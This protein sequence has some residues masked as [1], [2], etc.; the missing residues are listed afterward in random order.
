MEDDL[1][2]GATYVTPGNHP[3]ARDAPDSVVMPQ[4]EHETQNADPD[5]D[6]DWAWRRRI[7]SRAKSY[8]IYR[9][10]VG[11][12]GA[13]VTIGGLVLIPAPGP[14][15]LIVFLGLAILASEFE[16]ANR[17]LA[18]ARHR[19][20]RWTDWVTRQPLPVRLL[21]G[22]ATLTLLAGI[23][24]VTLRLAGVPAF[25]PDSWVPSWSGLQH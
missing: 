6:G 18:Y 14:G 15:W 13:V 8:L 2:T 7:R 22:L 16:W 3:D 21:L 11:V 9:I 25:V 20:G 5:D 23:F 17:L 10:V 19:V 12:V 4:P 24:W 1:G